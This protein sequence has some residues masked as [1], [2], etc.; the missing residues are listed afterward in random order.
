M[1][2]LRG[3]VKNGK[4]GRVKAGKKEVKGGDKG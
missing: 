3:R 2:E 1:K 4:R